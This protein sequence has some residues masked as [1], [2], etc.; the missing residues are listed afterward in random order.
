[1]VQSEFCVTSWAGRSTEW[2]ASL[3]E[4]PQFPLQH[5]T[6]VCECVRVCVSAHER[7]I[8]RARERWQEIGR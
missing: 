8:D 6:K 1:M 5:A 2:I 7:D 4:G 3:E